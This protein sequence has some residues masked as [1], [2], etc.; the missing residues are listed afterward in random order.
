MDME[1]SSITLIWGCGHLFN[2]Q[3]FLPSLYYTPLQHDF[4]ASP[5]EAWSL[6]SCLLESGL[7]WWLAWPNP[8][9]WFDKWNAADGTWAFW[10]LV[11][12]GLAASAWLVW[13]VA[14]TLWRKEVSLAQWR[15]RSQVGKNWGFLAN[16][17]HPTPMARLQSEAIL[18]LPAG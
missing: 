13:S 8:V 3:T 1:Q 5:L 6:F 7:A 17:R 2:A 14:P 10:S 4:T 12:T 15:V 18:D 11:L 16:T 9:I